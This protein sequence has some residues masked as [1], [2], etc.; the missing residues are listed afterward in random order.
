VTETFALLLKVSLV[1]FMAG[2]LLDMG[3]RLEVGA[4]LRGLRNLRFVAWTL[5]WGFVLG[6][7]LALAITK[8][9][10]LAPPYAM[11]LILIGMTPCAPFL[12]MV[13]DRARGDLAYTATFMVLTA[14]ATVVFMPFAIPLL[15]D[16]LSVSAWRIAKPL[17]LLI[18][19]PLAIGIAIHQAAPAIA[20]KLQPPVKLLTAVATLAT[21]AMILVIYGKDLLGVPGSLALAAQLLF[22]SIVTGCAYRF[23]FGLDDA[24][25]VVLSA[26]MATR[27]LGAAVAPLLSIVEIDQRAIVMVVLSL[28]VTLVFAMLVAVVT[29]KE[30]AAG[31]DH[32]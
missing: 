2:N 12:P 4:T 15:I 1:V 8:V 13:I 9:I 19:L 20:R 25:R 28:P 17:L 5:V 14:F 32:A 10:P 22:F 21:F 7:A 29:R 18:F 30:S 3:L 6:P 26:G 11:G 31:N 27:N 24:Q 23:A 16:G